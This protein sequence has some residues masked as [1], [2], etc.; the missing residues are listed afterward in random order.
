MENTTR[1]LVA[2]ELRDA[3]AQYAACLR[4]LRLA[5]DTITLDVPEDVLSG[6]AFL[7]ETCTAPPAAPD[8]GNTYYEVRACLDRL[9]GFLALIHY[10][11]YDAQ[12]DHSVSRIVAQAQDWCQAA[13]RAVISLDGVWRMIDPVKPDS[14]ARTD[15]EMF[16]AVWWQPVPWM[17]IEI[18]RRTEGV[19]IHD[20]VINPDTL[21]GGVAVRFAVVPVCAGRAA[22]GA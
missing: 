6:I 20:E 15:A 9:K 17:D 5:A 2:R 1:T 4:D 10:N 7:A 22:R 13:A 8:I 3:V 12:T 16:E 14:L 19:I 11:K 18:L 21:P